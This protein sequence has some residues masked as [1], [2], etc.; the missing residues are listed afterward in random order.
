VKEKVRDLM[1]DVAKLDVALIVDVGVGEN[2]DQ[3]H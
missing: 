3:A 1:Q 2:W